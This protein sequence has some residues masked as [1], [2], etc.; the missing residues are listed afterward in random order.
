LE[1]LIQQLERE[2]DM[3][4]LGYNLSQHTDN[5]DMLA[6]RIGTDPSVGGIKICHDLGEGKAEAS[7]EQLVQWLD[8]EMGMPSQGCQL[9]KR[10]DADE[11][12]L[13]GVGT[14]RDSD[15]HTAVEH[16]KICHGLNER[17]ESASLEQLIEQLDREMSM[18]LFQHTDDAG[19]C[20]IGD[21]GIAVGWTN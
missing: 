14:G 7:L 13:L 4:S 3:L 15:R 2:M 18:C 17:K 1:Q 11:P 10:A 21:D 20:K 19:P 16:V 12:D 8:R 5:P 6:I 9:L